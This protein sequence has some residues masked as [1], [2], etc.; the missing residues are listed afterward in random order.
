MDIKKCQERIEGPTPNG[1][2]YAMAYY[3][4]EIGTPGAKIVEIVEFSEDGQPIFSTITD[5]FSEMNNL[6][7]EPKH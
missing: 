2:A 7:N 1:G 4:D 5:S 3:S 6:L